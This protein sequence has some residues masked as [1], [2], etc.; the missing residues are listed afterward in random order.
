MRRLCLGLIVS[1]ALVASTSSLSAQASRAPRWQEIG[2][3][4]TGNKVFLDPRS[5]SRDSAGII[6]ATVRVIFKDTVSTPQGP[7]RSSRATAMF[8]CA[9]KQV[10]VKENIIFH[11]EARGTI[12][13]RSAPARPGYSPVFTSNFSGV[14]L[15]HLCNTPP[16]S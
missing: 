11:D 8:D 3:T 1:T 4:S 14:A 15:Q 9:K 6:T 7:I 10:A 2:V 5:V 16:P 13:R 12:Y